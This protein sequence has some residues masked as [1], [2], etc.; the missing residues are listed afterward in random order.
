[1]QLNRE[2]LL[3]KLEAV[4]PGLDKKATIE[5]SD[6]FVFQDGRV[7]TF[8]DEIAASCECTVGLEGAVK[9]EPLAQLLRKLTDDVIR[10][11]N[12]DEQFFV[13]TKSKKRSGITMDAEVLLPV[14]SIERPEEDSWQPLSEDFCEAV[15][16]VQNCAGKDESHFVLTCV[17]LTPEYVEACDNQQVTRYPIKTPF[18]RNFLIRRDSI[19]HVAQLGV[20]EFAE[21]DNWVHFRNSTGLVLSCR[22]YAEDFPD[23][24][25]ILATTGEKTVLPGGLAEACDKAGVFTIDSDGDNQVQVFLKE[26][27]LKIRGQGSTGW[28]EELSTVNYK[29]APL[30]FLIDPKLL[31]ELTKRTSEC[32][33]AEGRLVIRGGCF[34]YVACLGVAE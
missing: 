25:D 32:E 26:G 7:I 19:K 30:S 33:I 18:T 6:C 1:M 17:H 2:D 11:E 3:A 22:Q 16:I 15:Q 21:T 5:Q 34:V 20:S 14:D 12:K 9:A 8:N 13:A 23:M 31:V 27:Q 28:Y 4:V 10:V 24:A 29:G